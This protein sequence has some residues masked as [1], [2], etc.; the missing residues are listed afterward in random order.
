MREHWHATV[1][2]I[3]LYGVSAIVVINFWRIVAAKLGTMEGP[4]GSLG[5]NMGSLVHFGN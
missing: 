2:H 5:R 4:I 1:D 3:F